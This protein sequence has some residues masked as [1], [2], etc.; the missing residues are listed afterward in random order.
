M[1]KRLQLEGWEWRPLPRAIKDRQQLSHDTSEGRG[2]WF[3]LGMTIIPA[4]LRCLLSASELLNKFGVL[5]I[6]RYVGASPVKQYLHLLQGKPIQINHRTPA[7][8]ALRAEFEDEAPL[9]IED[10]SPQQR[11]AHQ[12]PEDDKSLEDAIAAEEGEAARVAEEVIRTE[13]P[14]GSGTEEEPIG[15]EIVELPGEDASDP[16]E[17]PAEA[18]PRRALAVRK[19]MVLLQWGPFVIGRGVSKAGQSFC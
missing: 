10:I 19:Q 11:D 14:V 12:N 5:T 18:V 1:A 9:A 16:P 17:P 3:T 15:N 2:P 8:L 13:E 4:Y 6:P 7:P